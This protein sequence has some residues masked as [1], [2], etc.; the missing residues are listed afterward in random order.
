MT[1]LRDDSLIVNATGS[2]INI[3]NGSFNHLQQLE[4][5]NEIH[6]VCTQPG[7][8][9]V[10]TTNQIVAASDSKL[11][12]YSPSTVDGKTV[13]GLEFEHQYHCSIKSLDWG[14]NGNLLVGGDK[15]SIFE[16]NANNLKTSLMDI[17]AVDLPFSPRK[18]QFSPCSKFVAVHG[19]HQNQIMIW[20]KRLHNS[21]DFL[22]LPHNR[23]VL[24][25]EWRSLDPSRDLKTTILT[26]S[27]DNI[28]RLWTEANQGYGFYNFDLA[29]VIDPSRSIFGNELSKSRTVD[30]SYIHWLSGR[31]MT[32]A[33]NLQKQIKPFKETLGQEQNSKLL[34]TLAEFPD[35][36]YQ[37]KPNGSMI[38]WGIQV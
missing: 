9:I 6:C 30:I 13:W 31:A 5:Q 38:V 11:L 21:F 14:S 3:Y 7:T 1:T 10:T 36:A 12:L 22:L 28:A 2:R 8:E 16:I 29:G 17:F 18:C 34:D 26:L 37:I 35:M 23:T 32:T 15:L 24:N 20:Y 27:E 4:Y 33:I 19:D 25:F